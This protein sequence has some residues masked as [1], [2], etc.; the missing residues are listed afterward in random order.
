MVPELRDQYNAEFTRDKY[1][2]FIEDLQNSFERSLGFRVCETPLFLSNELTRTLVEAAGEIGRHFLDADFLAPLQKAIPPG[3]R[4]P[5][6]NPHTDFLQV[7][8]AL[9]RTESG[10]WLP[11]LIELQGFPSLYGFQ[12]IL[13]KKIRGHFGISPEWTSYFNGL[14]GDAYLEM[15]KRKIVG[16]CDPENVILLEIEPKRQVTRI[17]FYCMHELLGIPTVCISDLVRR[18]DGLVYRAE[19][20]EVPVRRIY[21][22]I[23]FE[24]AV[25]TK[26]DCS[27]L[28]A[29]DLDVVWVGHPNWFFKISKYVLPLLRSRYCPTCHY[30]K[31]LESYPPDLENYVLKPLFSFA[32]GGV[33]VGPSREELD[34]VTDRANFILQRRVEY[35]PLIRTPEGLSKAEIRMMFLWEDGPL[36]INNLVR[37]SRGALMG[38]S[39][40]KEETWVGATIAYHAANFGA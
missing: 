3:L 15:L 13:N 40:N 20:R 25:R 39:S 37:T 21:N 30:L 28:F 34:A 17:D 4:I 35:A 8:F 12:F 11:Q 7:D 18:G 6:E 9:T 38:V 14:T 29:E 36:L 26:T 27:I 19:G 31:D 22:R 32:G 10:E 24:E 1:D 2:A 23:I 16:D 33:R 5:R